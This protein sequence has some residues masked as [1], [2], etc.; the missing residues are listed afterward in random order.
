MV[1]AVADAQATTF[2][3]LGHTFD[4]LGFAAIT[5]NPPL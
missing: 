2:Q 3:T 4:A 5:I 1:E